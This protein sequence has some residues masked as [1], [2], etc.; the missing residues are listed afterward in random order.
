MKGCCCNM[1][2]FSE[3]LQEYIQKS[4]MKIAALS[5]LSGVERS[6]I[7]KMLTGERIPGDPAVLQQLSE[8][9]MLTPS[10]HRILSEAYAISKMGEPTYY[11]RV[12]VKRLIEESGSFIQQ[13]PV[14]RSH[15]SPPG[16]QRP[17]VLPLTGKAAV[18]DTLRLLIEEELGTEAPCIKAVLQPE[19]TA[20]DVLLQYARTCPLLSIEHIVCFDSE[21]QYQKENKYNLHCLQ[22]ALSFLFSS[23]HYSPYFYYES[24]SAKSG[25]TTLFPWILLGKGWALTISQD[26]ERA[27]IVSTPDAI[28]L[29]TGLFEEIR[30][31]CLPVLEHNARQH[32]WNLESWA[33]LRQEMTY[34][35]QFEPCLGFFFTMDMAKKQIYRDHAQGEAL[36]SFLEQRQKQITLLEG[37]RKNTSFFAPEGLDR[38]LETGL[39][40]ELPEGSYAPLPKAYRAE[41][42]RRMMVCIQNGSYTPY[43]IKT[44]KFRLSD[45]LGFLSTGSQQVTCTCLHPLHGFTTLQLHEKSV[46]YSFCD[47]FEY[48][49][50]TGLVYSKEESESLLRSRLKQVF[51]G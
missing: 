24:I 48:L 45:K 49:R 5:K 9:L 8:V 44:A 51:N 12:L 35:L 4:N 7:Q 15:F 20:T 22:R 39:V 25:K 33:P 50:E 17:D 38:F 13:P 28:S 36:L 32:Y 30:T 43:L 1:S 27:L 21:L 14:L 19:C 41:L 18:A 37:T 3:K 31:E 46:A 6:F 16:F 34:S 2:V 11:R 10:Q 47:F 40:A 23:C 29:Y 42:L 26:E